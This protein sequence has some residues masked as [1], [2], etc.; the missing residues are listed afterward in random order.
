M[1]SVL[2]LFSGGRD[3]FLSACRLI[4]SGYHVY[5]VMYDS[6]MSAHSFDIGNNI[7]RLQKRYGEGSVSDLGIIDTLPIKTDLQKAW[8]NKEPHEL[9]S[10]FG[11]LQMIEYQCLTCRTAMYIMSLAICRQLDIKYIAEGARKVQKFAIEQT[12]VL[13]RYQKLLGDIE[14]ILPVHDL[15]SDDER[16]KELIDEGFVPK[17][18]E[19][20]CLMGVPLHRTA[21]RTELQGILK[22]LEIELNTC[23]D[24]WL[25]ELSQ[26]NILTTY[27][28]PSEYNRLNLI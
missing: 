21:T 1:K 2:L 25:N 3:S 26:A 14:L 18:I 27:V 20:K 9:A 16:T 17:T 28:I 7:I 12:D 5:T 10:K 11:N 19:S 24:K 22:L 23:A 4:N 8:Y 6:G 15:E 13:N